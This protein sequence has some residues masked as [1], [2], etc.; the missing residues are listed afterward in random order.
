MKKFEQYLRSVRVVLTALLVP[1]ILTSCATGRRPIFGSE[2][3][4]VNEK[5]EGDNGRDICLRSSQVE[6]K[7]KQEEKQRQQRRQKHQQKSQTSAKQYGE[8]TADS[9]NI[10]AGANLNY[11]ILGKLNEGDKISILNS[12]FGWYEI[13]LQDLCLGWIHKDYVLTEDTPSKEKKTVGIITG[14]SVRVRAKPGLRY[15]V[16]TK[17]NKG[18]KVTVVDLQ[19]DWFGIEPPENCT[20]WIFSN[21]VSR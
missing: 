15:T 10:R 14:N 3:Q 18:D 13:E 6:R 8:I 5:E 19:G 12:A 4:V 1:F 11:E 16:L 9:V 7:K 21:Y 2:K 20:G 17:V